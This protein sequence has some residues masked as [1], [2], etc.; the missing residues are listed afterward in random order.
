MECQFLSHWY[1]STPENSRRKRDSNSGSSALEADAIATRPTRRSCNHMLVALNCSL[2]PLTGLVST[3]FSREGAMASFKSSPVECSWHTT[4]HSS[5]VEC[6]WHTTY[7]SSPVECS[8]HTT[9]HSSPVECSWHTTYHS[10]PV[11]CSCYSIYH[12]SPVECSWHTTYHSSPVRC[13]GLLACPV[14]SSTCLGSCHTQYR[15]PPVWGSWLVRKVPPG[16]RCWC[17][18]LRNS[19]CPGQ[20]VWPGQ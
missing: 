18:Q 1:D 2:Q 16:H 9:Y 5:P 7:H 8:W 15:I 19:T 13:R 6:S 3:A 12:S 14:C 11:E 17:A 20:L 4:Y 10:S